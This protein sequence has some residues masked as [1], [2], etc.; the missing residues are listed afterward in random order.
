[1]NKVKNKVGVYI[2]KRERNKRT[3]QKLKKRK[4]QK[5]TKLNKTENFYLDGFKVLLCVNKV[6]SE[7]KRNC[8]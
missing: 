5:R 8:I 1:M 3:A 4:E 7:K 6:E 2:T